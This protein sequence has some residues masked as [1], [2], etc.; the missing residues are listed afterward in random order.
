MQHCCRLLQG[1]LT[2]FVSQRN[3]CFDPTEIL[4]PSGRDA[5]DYSD[6]ICYSLRLTSYQKFKLVPFVHVKN[7]SKDVQFIASLQ[8][9]HVHT[10]KIIAVSTI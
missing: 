6:M 3:V 5:C 10:V 7:A 4:G 9:I 2:S 1:K 8:L